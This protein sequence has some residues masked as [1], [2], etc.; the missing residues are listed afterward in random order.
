MLIKCYDEIDRYCG[1]VF[2]EVLTEKFICQIDAWFNG[3][4]LIK[5]DAAEPVNLVDNSSLEYGLYA[6]RDWNVLTTQAS[7]EGTTSLTL[8]GYPDVNQTGRIDVELPNTTEDDT[9]VLSCWSKANAAAADG[10]D[11]R[12]QLTLEVYYTDGTSAWIDQAVK[13]NPFV[14]EWQYSSCAFSL[15]DKNSNNKQDACIPCNTSTVQR[16]RKQGIF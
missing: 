7:Y 10:R 9:F 3:I 11:V 8:L 14:T 2:R 15:S 4:Q 1:I 16:K 5:G 13:F 6:W 12:Y